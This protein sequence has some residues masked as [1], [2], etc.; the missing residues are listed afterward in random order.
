MLLLVVPV[1]LGVAPNISD[2]QYLNDNTCGSPHIPSEVLLTSGGCGWNIEGRIVAGGTENG[3]LIAQ[4]KDDCRAWNPS[5]VIFSQDSTMFLRTYQKLLAAF[6]D[7]FE[8][9]DCQGRMWAWAKENILYFGGGANVEYDVYSSEDKL[10]LKSRSGSFWDSRLVFETTDGHAIGE[11]VM[12]WTKRMTTGWFCNGGYYH[13]RFNASTPQRYREVVLALAAIKSI[14][15]QTRNDEGDVTGSF[16][17]G[18][19]KFLTVGLPIFACVG[20][21]YCTMSRRESVV[22]FRGKVKTTVTLSRRRGEPK[23]KARPTIQFSDV[24]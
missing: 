14:R 11:A 2:A 12:E 15:D 19:W 13:V 16:C 8:L 20:L 3:K 5:D 21:C 9:R 4:F 23:A 10:I 17:H 6:G 18:M 1:V 7:V 24:M 22:K